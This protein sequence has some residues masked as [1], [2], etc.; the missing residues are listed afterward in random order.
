[1]AKKKKTKSNTPS[2]WRNIQQSFTGRAV[3]PH[4]RKRRWMLNLKLLGGVVGLALAG[5]ALWAGVRYLQSDSFARLMAGGS[6]PVRNVYLE[7]DGVL[8]EQWLNARIDLPE[9]IE[10]MAI[11]IDSMQRELNSDGQVRSVLVERVFPDALRIRISER[12]PVLRVVVQDAT[13]RKYLRL[14][15]KEG[16]V[17]PGKRYPAE[18]VRNLPYAA[19]VTLRRKV[20]GDYFPV[21]GVPEVSAF[22][23]HA[24]SLM[25]ERVQNWESVSLAKFDPSGK[26]HSSCLEV[27]TAEGYTIVFSPHELDEQFARLNAILSQMESQRQRV[28]RIDLS[29]EDAVVK[30]ADSTSRGPVRFR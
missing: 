9:N 25:P 10:L 26:A 28:D 7:S 17:Y 8:D 30:V 1:M 15:S 3:T 21:E 14:I 6:D 2:T 16:I 18:V 27:V 24:R 11:D 4:A 22:L 23:S 5:C 19:G 29:M 20:T 12:Q 13:G